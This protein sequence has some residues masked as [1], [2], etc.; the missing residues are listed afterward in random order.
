[1]KPRAVRSLENVPAYLSLC[2]WGDGPSFVYKGALIFLVERQGD[3][4]HYLDGPQTPSAPGEIRTGGSFGVA[5]LDCFED[6]EG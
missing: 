5:D 4:I 1:M 3:L 6:F 2:G